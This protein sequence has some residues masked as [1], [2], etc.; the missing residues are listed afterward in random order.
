MER[1]DDIYNSWSSIHHKLENGME[2]DHIESV[3]VYDLLLHI[4]KSSFNSLTV[5]GI[6]DT[7]YH[8]I[9]IIVYMCSSIYD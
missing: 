6:H 3:D 1:Y 8:S 9:C 4:Q 5:D 7:L 2:L